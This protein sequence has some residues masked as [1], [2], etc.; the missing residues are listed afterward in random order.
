MIFN[1]ALD[2]LI[3]F[4]VNPDGDI[5]YHKLGFIH[6][7]GLTLKELKNKITKGVEPY[8]QDAIVNVKFLNHRVTMLGELTRPQSIS[9]PEEKI[10]LLE[11][12]SLCGDVTQF[13]ERR[14]ILI[15]RDGANGKEIKHINLVDQSVFSSPWLYLQPNDIVYVRPNEYSLKSLGRV[16]KQQLVADILSGLTIF[17]ILLDRIIKR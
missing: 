13:A 10:S 8:L 4:D 5:Q 14:D 16:K 12:L 15:M 7:E 17:F 2:P 9:I 6:V 3:G 1:A 11:A